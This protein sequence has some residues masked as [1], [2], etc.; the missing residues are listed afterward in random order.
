V[1][2][3]FGKNDKKMPKLMIMLDS[4]L[5]SLQDTTLKLLM[6]AAVLSLLFGLLSDN[7]Y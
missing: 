5:D 6:G 3:S 4:F 2:D 7:K 1:F